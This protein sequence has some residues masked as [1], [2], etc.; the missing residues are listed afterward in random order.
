[1]SKSAAA[2]LEILSYIF[3]GTAIPWELVTSLQINL[4]NSDPAE[5]G[6][7]S[8][9]SAT[10]GGYAPVLV[11]RNVAGFTIGRPTV[12]TALITFP[13]CTTGSDLITH[14]SISPEGFDT[15]IYY[16]TLAIPLIVAPG[17]Q[18]EFKPGELTLTEN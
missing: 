17:I 13:Q 14:V 10:Y 1:M 18:P 6:I 16:G 5:D 11:P 4:H 7:A 12:N 2:E 15:I 9:F 3:N 8:N